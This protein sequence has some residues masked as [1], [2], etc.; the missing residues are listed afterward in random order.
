[1]RLN[2]PE[3]IYAIPNWKKAM[4]ILYLN[5]NSRW[6]EDNAAMQGVYSK[7]NIKRQKAEYEFKTVAIAWVLPNKTAKT[8]TTLSLAKVPEIKAVTKR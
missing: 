1:M 3:V 4:P 5:P 8:E 6:M 7:Q 2:K